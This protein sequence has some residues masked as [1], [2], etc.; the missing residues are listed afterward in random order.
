MEAE[1]I[2]GSEMGKKWG[3]GC[4]RGDSEVKNRG[5]GN[6][7]AFLIYVFNDACFSPCCSDRIKIKTFASAINLPVAQIFY[8]FAL[9]CGLP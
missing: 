3:S 9:K 1:E 5:R 2:R 6:L 4:N 8:P 7:E